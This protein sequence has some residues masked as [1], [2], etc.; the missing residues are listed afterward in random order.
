MRVLLMAVVLSFGCP[1]HADDIFLEAESCKEHTFNEAADFGNIVSGG[2][3]LRLWKGDIPP[4]EG[5]L[6]NYPFSVRDNA[7]Y[8]VWVAV[9]LPPSTSSFWCRLD[10]GEWQHVTPD[11]IGEF[12]T[13]YGVSNVMA[14]I[15]VTSSL[16]QAG[17]HTFTLRVNERRATLEQGYLLYVDAV[18]IT[19]RDVYP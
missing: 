18:L 2:K 13:Q 4:G 15:Q 7:T 6:A 10:E 12:P 5:Y 8:H 1:L 16:L 14:W 9:S 19:S 17:A 3:I 11:T